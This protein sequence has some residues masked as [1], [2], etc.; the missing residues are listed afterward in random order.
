M[1]KFCYAP[2]EEYPMYKTATLEQLKANTDFE[3]VLVL[4]GW[5][6]DDDYYGEPAVVAVLTPEKGAERVVL[7]ESLDFSDG[8]TL[9]LSNLEIAETEALEMDDCDS[10]GF[11][12]GDIVATNSPLYPAAGGPWLVR[13]QCH[14]GVEERIGRAGDA[15]VSITPTYTVKECIK[16][17]L[18][19]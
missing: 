4:W 18:M 2:A 10:F 7:L 13:V 8:E 12:W 19:Y 15:Y 6:K 9:D 11:D 3:A 1:L 16:L 5:G 14:Y 17:R